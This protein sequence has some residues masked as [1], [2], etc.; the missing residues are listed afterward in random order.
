MQRSVLS[1]CVIAWEEIKTE[2]IPKKGSLSN[3][4]LKAGFLQWI[5]LERKPFNFAKETTNKSTT[6]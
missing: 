4:R 5:I 6:W 3:A 1:I 2:N